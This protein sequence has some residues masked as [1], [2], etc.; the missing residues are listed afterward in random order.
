MDKRLAHVLSL[1]AGLAL[2]VAAGILAGPGRALEA[3]AGVDPLLLLPLCGVYG[4]SWVLRGVR[5]AMVVKALGRRTGWADGMCIELAADLANHVMP[6]RLGDA[7]KVVLLRDRTGMGWA[8]GVFASILTRALDLAV[9][10][11]LAALS[12]LLLP[13]GAAGGFAVQLAVAASM[14]AVLAALSI[15]FWNR[16]GTLARLMTGPL[17]RAAAPLLEL[18]GSLEGRLGVLPGLASVTAGV[19][20]FD[21]MTL[22][23]VMHGL[24][25]SLGPVQTAMALFLSNLAKAIPLAPNGIG[26]YEGAMVLI[27]TRL[28]VDAPRAFAA[29][30]LDHAFMNLFSILLALAGLARLRPG[31]GGIRGLARRASGEETAEPPPGDEEVVPQ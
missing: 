20:C 18:R 14:L 17:R 7:V 21:V 15:L 10:V 23:L 22:L 27:L 3:A 5:L 28:G 26:V 9:L 13:P 4:I 11:L 1:A 2:V 6:A 19:W 29:G 16:T 8:G 24:G 25:I 12:A 31:A 30:V